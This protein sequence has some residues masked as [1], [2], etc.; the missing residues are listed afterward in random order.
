[1][2]VV[3]LPRP[4]LALTAILSLAKNNSSQRLNVSTLMGTNGNAIKFQ[5]W[6]GIY[7]GKVDGTE[8]T[9]DKCS[10]YKYSFGSRQIK[11]KTIPNR[12]NN[13]PRLG[14]F[15]M[16]EYFQGSGSLQD[17]IIAGLAQFTIS[18]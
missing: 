2:S 7:A 12:S 1:M 9:M 10:L 14:L 3:N 16:I 5:K 15:S 8:F 17:N 6:H 13:T 11:S 18:Y 4:M